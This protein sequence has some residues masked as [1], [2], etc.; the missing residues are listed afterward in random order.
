M[1]SRGAE[2]LVAL[3]EAAAGMTGNALSEQVKQK[4]FLRLAKE[5]SA[6]PGVETE[7]DDDTEVEPTILRRPLIPFKK[8]E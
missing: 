4:R 7:D 2:S 1:S 8:K 6:K 3:E 5:Q